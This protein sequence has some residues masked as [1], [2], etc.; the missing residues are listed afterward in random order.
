MRIKIQKWG[1]SLALRIPQAFAKET[2]IKDK[3]IVN[4]SLEDQHL[5]ISP[6]D[7]QDEYELDTL[8]SKIEPTN[9]HSEI[10]FGQRAGR[11]LL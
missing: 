2:H 8:L 10:D 7:E 3:S 1:N 9:L 11:E 4:L 5:V 6:I